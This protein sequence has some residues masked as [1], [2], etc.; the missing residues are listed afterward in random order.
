MDGRQAIAGRGGAEEVAMSFRRA[1]AHDL[2]DIIALDALAATDDS[3]ARQI[4]GWIAEASCHVL[5]EDGIRVYG[6]LNRH[7]HGQP[8]I[9]L[10]MVDL[11]L[12]R[13]RYGNA[14]LQHLCSLSAGHHVWTST[15]RSNAA[16]QGLLARAGFEF[17]GEIDIDP[18]DPELYYCRRQT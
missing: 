15:N 7:F 3:R 16:M 11:H 14:L 6:V 9:E 8:F 18:G 4:E 2:G 1:T 12:R 5:D 10:L 17:R 13:M